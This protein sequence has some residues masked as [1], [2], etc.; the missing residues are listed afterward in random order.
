[1]NLCGVV[2][3]Y[4]PKK[5]V[6][7]NIDT[8]I[9]ELQKV[10]VIDNSANNNEKLFKNKKITYI[11]NGKNKGIAYALNKGISL[12][13]KDKFSYALTMDQDSYFDKEGLKEFIQKV[14]K[15]KDKNIAIYS[16]L[17][18]TD[19]DKLNENITDK[20]LVVMTS[21]NII[22]TDIW[23][24]VG[25]FKEWL[26]IDGV[27]QEYCLN[28]QKEGYKIKIFSDIILNHKLGNAHNKKILNHNFI[29]T[30][31]NYARRYFITRNRLYINELYKDV[32]RDFCEQELENSK[33]E[34]IKIILFEKDKL[35]KLKYIRKAKRDFKNNVKG[36]PSD[37]E[38]VLK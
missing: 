1:M 8:Y 3:T 20:S 13:C 22:S 14:E 19:N 2:V 33:K 36:I 32:F 12:A 25:G 34:K 10:Y 29:V 9:D 35:K 16:P 30:N 15:S 37:L 7:N 18:K 38:E 24:K 28:V 5:E 6:L 21:G 27:D 23:E 17:H 31:H 26:F 11:S 4:N